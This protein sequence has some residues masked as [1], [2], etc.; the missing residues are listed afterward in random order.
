MKTKLYVMHIVNMLFMEQIVE[1]FH[2][3]GHIC[4]G[5]DLGSLIIFQQDFSRRRGDGMKIV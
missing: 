2:C 5:L 3:H 4:Y 1:M